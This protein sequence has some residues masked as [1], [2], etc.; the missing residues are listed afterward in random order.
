MVCLVVGE[1][2]VGVF[3]GDGLVDVDVGWV[4]DDLGGCGDVVDF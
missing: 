2:G 1:V 4:G 3:V